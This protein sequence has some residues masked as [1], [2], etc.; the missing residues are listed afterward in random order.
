MNAKPIW[1]QEMGVPRPSPRAS[2]VDDHVIRFHAPRDKELFPEAELAYI[3]CRWPSQAQLRYL[4][5]KHRY[6]RFEFDGFFIPKSLA[7]NLYRLYNEY[8]TWWWTEA[9][10]RRQPMPKVILWGGMHDL[11]FFTV[12]TEHVHFWVALMNHLCR[13]IV[14]HPR[15]HESVPEGAT[16]N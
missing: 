13:Y 9:R 6:A 10:A 11:A 14:G 8:V 12:L 7:E 2:Y 3:R 5:Q 1:W 4:G 16:V 15:S